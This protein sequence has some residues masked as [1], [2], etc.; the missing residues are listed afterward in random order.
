[1]TVGSTSARHSAGR[2][3]ATGAPRHRTTIAQRD[4]LAGPLRSYGP[5]VAIVAVQQIAFP[6][7]SGIVVRG[8]VVGG[9]TALIALGMALVYRANRIINFAQAD[10]GLAP[11]ILAFLLL[12]QSGLPYPVAVLAGL[13]AAVALGAA[14]ERVVI[15]RFSRSP[16]LLVT[17]ATIGLSQVLVAAGMLLPRLWDLDLIAGRIAPPVDATRAIGSIVFDA[18]DLL[19]LVVTPILILAVGGFLRRSDTGTAIRASADSSDRASLLGVPVDRLQTL[20]WSVAGLLAFAAVFLRSGILDLPTG[21]ALGFGVL[22]RALVAL[23]LGRL[24]DLPGVTS[25]AVALGVL[26]MGI[27]WNHGSSVIDPF[28]GLVVVAALVWRRREVGRLDRADATAWRAADEVRPVPDRLATVPAARAARWGVTGLVAAVA[29]A[30]PAVLGV[31]QQFKA[32]ALLIY[33]VLGLS[34]VLLSGW[35]GIVSLGQIAFFAVGA[36]VTGLAVGEWQADLFGALVVAMVVGAVVATVVGVPAVRLR[37]LYLAITTFAFALATT[38]Y[39]L[40]D[41]YFG[42]VP[43]DRLERAPLLGGFDVASETAVYYLALAVLVAVMAG[44]RGIRSSRFGRALVALR[45]NEP[46]AE[47]YGVDPVRARLTAFAL[48]GAVAALAGGLFVHHERA[49]DPA[50]YSPIENLVVL[51]MVVVGGMT[52][53]AGAV[54]GALFLFGGRWF[55]APEWQFLASGAGVLVVLLAAPG[56]IA[57]LAFRGRDRWL[58]AVAARHGLTVPGYGAAPADAVTATAGSA[59]CPP[60]AGAGDGGP[61]G[62]GAV[63]NGTPGRGDRDAPSGDR[64]APGVRGPA[65]DR[66]AADD[67][68]ASCDPPGGDALLAVRD[69]EVG[70]GGVPVLFG[71]DLVVREGEAVALLGTNGAGK[72]TLLRAV[73]GVVPPAAGTVTFAGSDLTGMRPHEIAARGIVQMPGGA[74]I[75]PSLTIDENLRVAGWLH[76]RDVAGREAALARVRGLFPV[77]A[78]RAGER[79]GNLSGGQQQMLALAMVVLMRPRLVMIDEL[80]LGLAPAVVSELLHFMDDLRAEGTTLVVVEQS[81]NVALEIADRAVFLER[82]QV[83]FSGPAADLLDRPDLVR[84]VFLGA[85]ARPASSV[86]DG[87]PPEAGAAAAPRSAARAG[88]EGAAPASPGAG[89][90]NG[91]GDGHADGGPPVLRACE[92]AVSFG[93][94]HAV[95]GVSFDVGQREIVGVI[96]PNGAGKSTLF[97]LLGG[98]LPAARGQVE[99]AGEDVTG[100]RAAARAR[101]GLGRSFQDARLFPAL[102]VDEAVAVAVERWVPAGDPLSAAF[103]LPNALDSEAAVRRRVDELVDLLG[104]GDHRSLF[105][106]ELST[107]TRRIVDLACLLAHRPHVV[108]LDEPA[109]GIAQR[110]VE[111]LAPLI[112][113]VRDE[114]GASLVVVEHDLPLVREVADRVV[115]MDQGRVLA[116]GAPADVLADPAVV[117]AYVGSDERAVHRSGPATRADER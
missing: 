3:R 101:R 72:S 34:L 97:D 48:S 89:N 54:L 8:L 62:G 23:L 68:P 109:S 20:V 18:N 80:S 47:S 105:V 112:R 16:R 50:S 70:Y 43:T 55:L 19:G 51:T 93:G 102:T 1:M 61:P 52:S 29:V 106:R 13:A 88:A 41:D 11:T 31:D 46:A 110:E 2:G 114:T 60:T 17:I 42:W 6:A 49:F 45:D 103:H 113:R 81:I 63:G 79:A 37:G 44:M 27:G 15:R 94:V 57:G 76:R 12:D 26:E 100:R 65:G 10:L 104:L 36:A 98:A 116:D 84:S 40:N 66:D 59:G 39:L 24:T 5:A 82:G 75:F 4:R 74:G 56:G 69:L 92:L 64:V 78:D 35:G 85:A 32:A 87:T 91:D 28:L 73:S 96:G 9:L 33:A 14:T 77:L 30:L 108:L 21:T 107:G 25:A 67:R 53:L 90:G 22:L 58:R 83:R 99:L 38:S 117:A 115:A 7:P 86:E 111:Q 95:D 71:V